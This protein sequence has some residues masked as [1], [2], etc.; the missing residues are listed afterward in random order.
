MNVIKSERKERIQEILR[1]AF[2]LIIQGLVFQLQS[3]TDKAFLGNLDT[4]YVSAVGAAQMPYVA[5]MDSIV[6]ISTGL[7]IVVSNLYGAG[8]K[9]TITFFVKSA[10]FFNTILGSLV[11][12]GWLFGASAILRFFQVNSGIINYSISYV[13]ICAVFFLLV[14]I[15]SSMQAMLQAMG[16]TRPIMY[17]GILK[18]GLN[19]FISWILIFGKLG[20]PAL[21]VRGAAIGTLVANIASFL[22]VFTY[23]VYCK[24][25]QYNLL[26]GDFRGVT[27]KN[28][29]EVM[30]LGVPVGLE[31]LLWNVSNLLLIRFVNGFSYI[32][33]A[34]YT[35][36]FG[37]QCVI[38]V[39]F[40]G[41]SKATLSLMGQAL[42][43]ENR[44]KAGR[45]FYTTIGLNF[46]IVMLSA[47]LFA[48]FPKELLGIF[49]NDGELIH[50]GAVYLTMMG[51]IMIPQSMNIICGNAIRAYGN[52]KWMLYSQIFGSIFVVSLSTFL[53]LE[54]RMNMMAIYITLFFDEA[55]RGGIN[56][57]YYRRKYHP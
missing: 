56:Y 17:A 50:K 36:T 7:I 10:A 2:P 46:V 5:T 26:A 24:T 47:V 57:I 44:K 27:F 22:F 35:L 32:D 40:E 20:F 19:I 15:D 42:G 38:Y 1:V 13:K 52:T 23:C 29:L 43:A 14:G 6:A 55:I 37:F 48:A 31:Y 28:Y 11:F 41:T 45:Y 21:Y 16:K 4:K 51:V 3:L 25:R 30:R 49:S 9:E 34:I 39:L 12:A 18:V 54:L 33:M 8:K 53:V